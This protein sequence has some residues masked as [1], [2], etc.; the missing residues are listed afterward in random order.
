[1]VKKNAK[2]PYAGIGLVFGTAIGAGLSLILTG[3]VIWAGIGTGI[4]L[5]L[6]AIIEKSEANK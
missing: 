6:G 4:G 1:M 2:A 3:T 5:I